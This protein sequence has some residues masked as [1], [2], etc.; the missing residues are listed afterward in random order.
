MIII[1]DIFNLNQ[2]FR[3]FSFFNDD[4]KRSKCHFARRTT[5]GNTIDIDN[6]TFNGL[7]SD[8]NTR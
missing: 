6:D 8:T 7:V 1:I 4:F 5:A 2:N 3:E